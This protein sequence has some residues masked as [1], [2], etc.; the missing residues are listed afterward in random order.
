MSVGNS[1]KPIAL[2]FAVASTFA[3]CFS[4][5][6]IAA[7]ELDSLKEQLEQQ[8]KI[9][10]QQQK[11]IDRLEKQVN[12]VNASRQP[13]VA[14]ATKEGT[15]VL[16]P[17]KA[18][19]EIYG[20]F[21]P[22][23]ETVRASGATTPAPSPR[24]NQ[25]AATAFTGANQPA[26]GR[27]T[28][29]T[30]HIGF[31]G[32]IGIADD[33]QALW[34]I[35]AGAALDGDSGS[36][37]GTNSFGL[38]NSRL[39]FGGPFGTVFYGNWD[40]PYKWISMPTV[41]LKGV[42]VFDYNAIIGNPGFGVFGT[43][44]Q[45]G[46]AAGKAD[47]AFDRRQGNSIQYWTPVIAGFSARVAYSFDEGRS[48]SSAS[49]EIDPRI[50]SLS[51]GYSDG[52]LSVQYAYEQHNDYFGMSQLGGA[53]AATATNKSSKDSGHKLVGMYTAGKTRFTAIY[54]QLT[55]KNRDSGVLANVKE[56]KRD[57]YLFSVQRE[58]GPGK[59]WASYGRAENGSCVTVGGTS[60]STGGLGA[61]T[62]NLGYSYHMNKYVDLFAA[63]YE[64]RNDEAGTYQPVHAVNI[65]PNATP[66]PGLR[67]QGLG[68]GAT[69]VF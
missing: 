38:R 44:T 57:A 8:R 6:A 51:A 46:R 58:I 22:F 64:I 43:T 13:R 1:G 19:V 55:Y 52:P 48:S 26:R 50:W 67:I 36:I 45:F 9:L 11:V 12:D 34:Q 10:D 24:P 20:G 14:V 31:R 65:A 53:G 59:A 23:A 16:V 15:N 17:G 42:G 39:G 25:L 30:S 29:G 47:A 66:A 5:S 33:Y 28:V 27:L 41:P 49:T 4:T 7:T 3:L 37:G 18:Q 60:C 69:L 21:I 62:W 35:E 2:G 68:V 40:T 56:Y 63:Y 61:E 32:A 54:E